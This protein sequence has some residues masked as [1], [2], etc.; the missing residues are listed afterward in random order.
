MW[1][2]CARALC[3]LT[4]C[5]GQASRHRT[6]RPRLQLAATPWAPPSCR[7]LRENEQLEELSLL[8]NP[9]CRWAGYRPY[10][11]GTLPRLQRLDGEQVGR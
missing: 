7:S 1:C 11:L 6:H 3:C 10:V 5:V 2:S 8:G 4:T 9:C